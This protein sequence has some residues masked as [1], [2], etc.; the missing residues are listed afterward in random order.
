MIWAIND[1]QPVGNPP[2]VSQIKEVIAEN[3]GGMFDPD[4]H[5]V[6]ALARAVASYVS[7]A[8]GCCWRVDAGSLALLTSKALFSVGEREAAHRLV[9]FGTGLVRPSVWEIRGGD[10]IWTL[11]LGRM[12]PRTETSL[13]MF[14][15][16]SLNIVLECVADVWDVTDGCGTLALRHT[17]SV[18][19]G[20]LGQV[21]S[22]RSVIAFA[23]EI[24]NACEAKLR[25]LGVQR[26]WGGVPE[27]L[28]MDFQ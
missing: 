23:D 1:Q 5:R 20:I 11:D 6:D 4:G 21:R 10:S 2:L 3:G 17:R 7:E 13:E 18:A 24:R 15:F 14:F 22:G 28:R 25:Q 8:G 26:H 12:V 27:L 19:A 9:V 16:S